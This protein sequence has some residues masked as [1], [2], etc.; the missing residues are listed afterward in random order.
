MGA[1]RMKFIGGK[2]ISS[3]ILLVFIL[4]AQ[5]YY[6][7]NIYSKDQAKI[8][9]QV[10]EIQET[11]AYIVRLEEGLKQLPETKKELETIRSKQEAVKSTM[12]NMAST[13][14]LLGEIYSIFDTNKFY[15]VQVVEVSSV[16]IKDEMIPIIQKDYNVS[17]TSYYGE[18][19]DF[20]EN[21]N[22][23][24]QIIHMNNIQ[25]DNQLQLTENEEMLETLQGFFGEDLSEVVSV[26][27]NFSIYVRAEMEEEQE[28]YAVSFNSIN[29]N[30]KP[31]DGVGFANRLAGKGQAEEVVM[32]SSVLSADRVEEYEE[33]PYLNSVFELY[34]EDILTSGD[35][36]KLMGT[37]KEKQYLGLVTQSNVYITITINEAGYEFSMEDENGNVK[38]IT[39]A[40][41]MQQPVL[42]I[43]SSMR[44]VQ[45]AMPHVH[46]Y[47]YNYGKDEIQVDLEGSLLSHIHIYDKF[48]EEVQAGET[49]GNVKLTEDE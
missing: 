49:K 41:I 11:T 28:E 21:I 29:N 1:V 25:I 2:K 45:N 30:A 12:P 40:E 4:G 8:N 16:P 18:V 15:D 48:D 10:N 43:H 37:G 38:Q 35:T 19:K 3:M 42:Y 44:Q 36:Y 22:G 23:A 13:A 33:I 34:V 9:N 6:L 24:Y 27:L 32:S 46:I 47:V 5:G 7:V 31:F 17:F 39:C 14:K 26:Q 20:I